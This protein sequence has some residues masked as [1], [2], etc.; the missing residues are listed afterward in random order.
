MPR[1]AVFPKCYMDELCITRTMSVFEW[2]DLAAT[3]PVDGV[4]MYDAFF[5]EFSPA[6]L[7]AVRARL[8]EHGLAMPMMCYSPDFTIPDAA[9]RQAEVEKERRVLA[10]TAVLGGQFCRVLSGQRRPEVSPAQGIE[11]VVEAITALLP[12]AEA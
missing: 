4:E 8:Q 7:A 10:V 11:W 12:D 3:L 2:I 5:T 6:Y 1:L 9:A